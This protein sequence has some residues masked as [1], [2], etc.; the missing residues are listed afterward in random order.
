MTTWSESFVPE[1]FASLMTGDPRVEAY[2][3]RVLD[4]NLIP[5][6][7]STGGLCGTSPTRHLAVSEFVDGSGRWV[8]KIAAFRGESQ[9]PS[10]ADPDHCGAFAYTA[11]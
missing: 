7:R 5:G 6:R 1:S 9:P 10:S 11:Q 8:F 3:Y 2:L 4:E